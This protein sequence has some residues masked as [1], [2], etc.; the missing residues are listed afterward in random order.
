L[1][2]D[3]FKILLTQLS[4]YEDDTVHDMALDK[5]HVLIPGILPKVTH[6]IGVIAADTDRFAAASHKCRFS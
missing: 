4:R 3:V 2:N 6:L 5:M 1:P